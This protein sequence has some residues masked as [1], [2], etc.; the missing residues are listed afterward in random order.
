M[1]PALWLLLI[2]ATVGPVLD[3]LHTFSGMTW[4]PHPQWLRS[5]WWVSQ[6]NH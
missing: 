6:K 4:Y 5:V 1:R 2:G 3:G